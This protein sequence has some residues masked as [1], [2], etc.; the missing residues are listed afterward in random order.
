MVDEV[1]LLARGH[2][3]GAELLGSSRGAQSFVGILEGNAGNFFGEIVA[4]GTHSLGSITLAAVETK[5]EPEEHEF[6]LAFAHDFREALKGIG[7]RD[8][9]GLDGMGRDAKG[10][11]RREANA[12]L[13]VI[14]GENGMEVGSQ[15]SEGRKGE[16]TVISIRCS[17]GK[18]VGG[19]RS[20]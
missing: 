10:S 5:G 13:A 14:D 8:R 2:A 3:G 19:R 1:L 4:E 15:R 17:G 12:G 9:D 11:G 6:D 7:A 20:G 16:W 18:G